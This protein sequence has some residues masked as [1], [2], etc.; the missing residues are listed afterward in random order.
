MCNMTGSIGE[1]EET[2]M[3]I[4]PY[5]VECQYI[6]A[7]RRFPC[8]IVNFLFNG[9]KNFGENVIASPHNFFLYE[10][11]RLIMNPSGSYPLVIPLDSWHTT[12]FVLDN[13]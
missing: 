12:T 6:L 1:S 11:R 9:C 5:G 2:W 7:S 13:W 4:L 3:V 8:R 10:F